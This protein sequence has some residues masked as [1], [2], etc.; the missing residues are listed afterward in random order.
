MGG[1][2]F[3]LLHL[4]RLHISVEFHGERALFQLLT[5]ADGFLR[6]HLLLEDVSHL[7]RPLFSC[8]CFDFIVV[9][10]LF[11]LHDGV[12][13]RALLLGL[14]LGVIPQELASDSV[15]QLVVFSSSLVRLV[16]L[17]FKKFF[18]HVLVLVGGFF[19]RFVGSLLF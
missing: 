15:Y 19:L 5:V 6:F 8:V 17:S 16:R 1:L 9:N 13:L 10:R 14:L 11:V 7:H 18:H 3:L 2:L 4:E 12:L